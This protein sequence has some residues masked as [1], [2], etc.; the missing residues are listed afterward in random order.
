MKVL[1]RIEGVTRLDRM[2]NVDIRK[3]RQASV[4]DAVRRRQQRWRFRVKESRSERSFRQ[5]YGGDRPIGI[6][7]SQGTKQLHYCMAT[8]LSS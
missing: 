5:R 3:R 7:G 6:P 4:L 1:R 8:Y 2:R